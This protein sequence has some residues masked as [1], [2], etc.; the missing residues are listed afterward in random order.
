MVYITED[1]IVSCET[2]ILSKHNYD[3]DLNNNIHEY[4]LG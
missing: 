1:V 2:D 4:T 3:C